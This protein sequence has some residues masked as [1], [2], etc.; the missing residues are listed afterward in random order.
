MA[1]RPARSLTL[2][3]STARSKRVSTGS[4]RTTVTPEMTNQRLTR[5]A[6]FACAL[7][8]ALSACAA[9]GI[10][11]DSMV[12]DAGFRVDG[13]MNGI[14][15]R[16]CVDTGSPTALLPIATAR[17]CGLELFATQMEVTDGTGATLPAAGEVDYALQLGS[18]TFHSRAICLHAPASLGDGLIGFDLVRACAWLFDAPRGVVHM[19]PAGDAEQV[20]R[21]CGYRVSDVL[22]LG[23]DEWRPTITVRL[24]GRVE[25]TLLLDTGAESTSLPAPVVDALQL[26]CGNELARQRSDEQAAAIEAELRRHGVEARVSVPPDEGTFVGVHGV[27]EQSSLHHLRRLK[28]G[29]RTFEDLVVARSERGGVL[30]RDVLGECTW[31]LHGPRRE[32]WLLEQQ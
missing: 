11:A 8:T 26:P 3:A 14:P 28:L 2:A 17:R 29:S 7:G 1:T 18:T 23:H 9:Y 24:D 20:L 30:G 4:H 25:A 27:I 6:A 12:M 22:T 13:T 15:V 31:L 19:A 32:L 16:M 21:D 10:V 5:S